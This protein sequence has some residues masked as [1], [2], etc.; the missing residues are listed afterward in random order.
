MMGRERCSCV[1]EES[2]SEETRGTCDALTVAASL[3]RHRLETETE[4]RAPSPREAPIP[5]WCP[6]QSTDGP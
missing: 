3:S 2:V 6:Y 5:R 1:M 4:I